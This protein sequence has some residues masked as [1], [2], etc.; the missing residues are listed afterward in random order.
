M[1]ATFPTIL[2]APAH[3]AV[4]GPGPANEGPAAPSDQVPTKPT[5]LPPTSGNRANSFPVRPL[6]RPDDF[7]EINHVADYGYRWY[8]PQTGRWPSR[9]PIG[10]EGGVNLYGF[11]GN[12]GVNLWDYLGLEKCCKI[13]L[14]VDG[15]SKR[16]AVKDNTLNVAIDTGH[17]WVVLSD[18]DPHDILGEEMKYSHGPGAPIGKDDL[19]DFKDGKFPGT[20]DWETKTHEGSAV[21]KEWELEADECKKAKKIIE[22]MK[23]AVPN[24]SPANQCTSVA[25]KILN[26][27][28]VDPAPP[29]GVGYVIAERAFQRKWEGN[30]ANPYHLN[31]QLGGSGF[32]AANS[33]KKVKSDK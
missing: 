20:A 11:V 26:E 18:I 33:S 19:D 27:I 7:A 14:Y 10:E 22:D 21:T 31:K 8:D 2:P 28:P 3:P 1:S 15:P 12:D 4:G 16:D 5:P 23:K 24:Y 17:T 30:A 29:D 13:T 9:D 25:L 32:G 6:E